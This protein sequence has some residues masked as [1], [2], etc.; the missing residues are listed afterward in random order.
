MEDARYCGTFDRVVVS[1]I[2]SIDV[3]F[4]LEYEYY[5]DRSKVA[6][7]DKRSY[8]V[9]NSTRLFMHDATA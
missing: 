9:E 3:S 6:A 5:H 1:C 8:R 4:L 2:F 7:N